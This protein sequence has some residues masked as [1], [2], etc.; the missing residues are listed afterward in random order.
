MTSILKL[1]AA[2]VML[3]AASGG[4]LACS[5]VTDP[6]MFDALQIAKVKKS[7]GKTHFHDAN[8][9]AGANG[10]E[11]CRRK[12]FVMP[13]DAVLIGDVYDAT[14][15]TT[16]VDTKGRATSGI[17]K[18]SSVELDPRGE[19]RAATALVGRWVREEAEINIA[20]RGPEYS[21]SGEATYGAR[22][23]SRVARGAVNIG[24]FDFRFRPT[25]NRISAGIKD[26]ATAV[27]KAEAQ[28]S[29]CQ[30]DMI[31]LGPYLVVRDNLNCGG[32]NVSFTGIYRRK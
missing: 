8:C 26:G 18:G 28:E 14:A 7:A 19:S 25:T 6:Q 31:A 17:I 15:C 22:D 12:S 21:V 3:G 2:V 5:E 16:Y 32:N 9:D 11:A 24:N 23:P 1:V 10:F 4:A 27:A 30:I 29:D 20:A 13:G